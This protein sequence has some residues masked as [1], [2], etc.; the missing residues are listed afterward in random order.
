MF[1]DRYLVRF[2]AEQMSWS[3]S[4][5]RDH[6]IHAT[7]NGTHDQA[8]NAT[9]DPPPPEAICIHVRH[10]DKHLEMK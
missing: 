6:L 8:W 7:P 4:Y 5:F 1:F 3:G 10:G 2:N 9:L